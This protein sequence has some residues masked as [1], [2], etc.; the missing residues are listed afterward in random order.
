MKVL[1]IYMTFPLFGLFCGSLCA[2]FER[3]NTKEA[4]SCKQQ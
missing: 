1:L 3:I 2:A 4:K